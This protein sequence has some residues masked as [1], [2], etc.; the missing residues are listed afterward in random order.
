MQVPTKYDMIH[1]EWGPSATETDVWAAST[2]QKIAFEE[3]IFNQFR[4]NIVN[5]Q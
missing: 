5:E 2:Q 3:G 1:P 4:R